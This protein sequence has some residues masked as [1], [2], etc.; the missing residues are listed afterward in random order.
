MNVTRQVR[1]FVVGSTC[2]F[3]MACGG[4][5]SSTK[6]NTIAMSGKNVV[7]I[8]AD[9]GPLLDYPDATFASVTVCASGTTTCQTIPDVLV[10]TGS[11]GLRI[12]ASQLTISLTQQKASD[13]NSV[14]ECLQ[15]LGSFT[16]GPVQTADIEI[17]GEKASSVPIQVLSDIESGF[18]VPTSCSSVSGAASSA[19]TQLSLGANGILGVGSFPQ[20]CGGNPCPASA[21]LYYECPSSGCFA[22]SQTLAQQVQNPVALFATDNNGVIIEL[23]AVSGSEATVS[24]SMVF[25]I[26]TQSNNAL[27]GATVYTVDPSTGNFSTTFNGTEY[28]DESFLDTGSNGYFFQDSSIPQCSSAQGFYCPT[29]TVNLS[30]K[31]QG[32]T[33]GSGTV[34][35][36][37]ANAETLFSN[38]NDFVFGDLGGGLISGSN[39]FDW[40]LPFFYGRNVFVSIEGTSAPGGTTPYWA[41]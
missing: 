25:G 27:G 28:P 11:V 13:G 29:S 37:I 4:S 33:T 2:A 35:F 30:A 15:F 3:L 31:N 5:S 39:S 40:G 8:T 22:V 20:D 32:I 18:P 24:G 1:L 7:A 34:N 6:T 36:S 14:A 10:D 38:S 41:Y 16:W 21:N 23:P 17:G 26:G 9:G 19:D 12:L